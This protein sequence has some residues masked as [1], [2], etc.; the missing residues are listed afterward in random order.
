MSRLLLPWNNIIGIIPLNFHHMKN[1][2]QIKKKNV[3]FF[4]SV[5]NLQSKSFQISGILI[6]RKRRCRCR[7]FIQEHYILN[8]P[9]TLFQNCAKCIRLPALGWRGQTMTTGSTRTEETSRTDE[10]KGI[11]RLYN[12]FRVKTMVQVTF[13]K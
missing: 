11:V 4:P 6:L 8:I 3:S 5:K 7:E 9:S 1:V 10:R 2:H 13:Q 12:V